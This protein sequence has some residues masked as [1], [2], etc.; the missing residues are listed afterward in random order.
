MPT[1]WCATR[2]EGSEVSAE[3]RLECEG[4]LITLAGPEGAGKSTQLAGLQ[5]RLQGCRFHLTETTDY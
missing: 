1:A 4:L 2:K 3:S 5:K